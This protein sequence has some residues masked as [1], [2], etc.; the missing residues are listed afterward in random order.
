MAATRRPIA[1][2]AAVATA[3]ALGATFALPAFANDGAPAEAP[4]ATGAPQAIQLES[5]TLDWGVRASFRS[6]ID[7]MG[8]TATLADGATKNEDGTYRFPLL[9][10][11]YD[12]GTHS[13]TTGFKGSVHFEAHG[14]VLDI[15]L[16]DFKVV[17]AGESG[18]ITVD[19]TTKSPG[20][21]AVVSD[22][23]EMAK[24]DLTAVAPSNGA[25]GMKFAGVPATFTKEGA[26]VFGSAYKEGDAMDPATLTVKQATPTAP[27]TTA[28]PT[29]PP[30]TPPATPP[31]TGEPTAKPTPTGTPEPTPTGTAKPTSGPVVDGTLDWGVKESFRSYVVGRIAHGRIETTDGATANDNGYRFTKA[32]GHLDAEKNSLNARF[33]GKVRFLGHETAGAYKL[34]LSLSNLKVDVQGTTGKLVADVSTKD[35]A[36]GKASTYTGLAFADLKVPAGALVAKEGVVNLKDIPATLTEDGSKAFSRMYHKGDE[37]DA[38]TAAVSLDKDATLPPGGSTEYRNCA[39]AEA[40]GVT[41]IKKGDPGYA[42]HL[43]RDGDGIACEAGESTG[44]SGSAGGSTTGGGT[45]GGSTTGGSTAGGSVGGSGALASTGSDVPTGLLI[46]A[47]GL[48]VAAGAGVMIAARRRRDAGDAIA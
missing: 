21:D 31:V 33:E 22:D 3:A 24:L 13:V 20:K 44:G 18:R 25:D 39:E 38:L 12:R 42:A 1:L 34:D 32:T 41:P 47:S 19:V 5:G 11:E 35:M 28:P 29:T 15:E 17:T 48:V 43:D 6:M 26:A 36:S 23:L 7:R 10:G 4:A 27:P 46:G 30:A 45:V 8:G 16:A 2:A 37:L 40:A 14:G 9:Q